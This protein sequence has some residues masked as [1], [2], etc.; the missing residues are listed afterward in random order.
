MPII[1][2]IAAMSENQVIGI[3]NQLPWHLPD[4]WKNFRKITDGKAFI[5]GRKSYQAPDALHSTYRDVVLTKQNDVFPELEHAHSLQHAFDILKD[6]SEVFVL[7]GA[8]VFH[9]AIPFAD[10]MYLTVVHA[11]IEGDAYFPTVKADEWD[12]ET[13]V[14]HAADEEHKYAF[15]MNVLLRKKL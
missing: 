5:T 4:E 6:E 13:S 8:S 3:D 10:K 15:S 1:N 2:L 14:Y 11:H 7:G 9:A 12:L